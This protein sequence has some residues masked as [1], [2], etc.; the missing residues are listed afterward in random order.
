MGD[1]DQ[2]AYLFGMAR[3]KFEIDSSQEFALRKL[4]RSY[5]GTGFGDYR[6][7]SVEVDDVTHYESWDEKR[8]LQAEW[9]EWLCAD[10]KTLG[11]SG[12]SS[13]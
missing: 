1:Q 4:L 10:S 7:G 9:I 12:S 11:A 3:E 13:A 5:V 8:T 2:A 6:E